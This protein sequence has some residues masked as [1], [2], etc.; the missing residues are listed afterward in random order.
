MCRP[1]RWSRNTRRSATY[2]EEV[3]ITNVPSFLHSRDL[4][5]ECPGLGPLTVDVA[6]GGNFYCIV[7]PQKNFTDL[8]DVSVGDLLRWSP[9][10]RTAI[11]ARYQFVHPENDNIRGCTHV[12]WTGAPTGTGGD[13]AQR[14]VLRRQG[15]RPLA[16]RHR[17]L[18]AHGAMV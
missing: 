13:R 5:I 16:L 7:D 4:E 3:R 17:H 12:M 8:A 10:L 9:A 11:N 18:G 14:G 15:H 6:Y 1:G 2:V